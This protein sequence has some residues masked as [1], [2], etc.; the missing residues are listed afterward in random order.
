MVKKSTIRR[1]MMLSGIALF[2]LAIC[3]PFAL[4]QEGGEEGVS[5]TG[6]TVG[7]G[8]RVTGIA[9]S[10]GIAIAAG[11]FGTARAQSAIGAGGTGALAEKPE[12]FT[13]ILILVAIPETLV[14]FGFV[15]AIMLMGKI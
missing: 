13:N 6:N 12:L 11:A 10:A 2:A 8:I 1:V 5:A 9:I 4:A 3:A 15:I 14:V 7:D